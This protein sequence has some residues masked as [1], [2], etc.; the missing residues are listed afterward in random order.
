MLWVCYTFAVTYIE[1]AS[2]STKIANFTLAFAGNVLSAV[3]TVVLT[4]YCFSKDVLKIVASRVFLSDVSEI[5]AYC[6]A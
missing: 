5:L 1:K 3:Y 2:M 6:L 4:K